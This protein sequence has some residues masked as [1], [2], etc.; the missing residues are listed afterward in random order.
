M[1]QAQSQAQLI[2]L[3]WGTSSLRAYLL[4]GPEKVV[5]SRQADWGIMHL[6]ENGFAGA[7]TSL[8]G[9]WLMQY[10][11]LPILAAG[12]VGSAQGWREAP[13]VETPANVVDLALHLVTTAGP[14]GRPVH[15]APGVIAGGL[16]PNVMRGE[17]TQILGALHLYPA[18]TASDQE[19]LI[20]LPGTHSKW[21]KVQA[22]RI[23][24]FTTFM[25]GEVYSALRQH[26]ILG[27]LMSYEEDQD[28]ER[29]SAFERG[30][31][32]AR[33]HP[34]SGVLSKLISVRTLGLTNQLAPTQLADYLSGLLIGYEIVE[35]I[36]AFPD[37]VSSKA[38]PLILIGDKLLCERYRIAISH[39]G[40]SADRDEIVDPTQAGLWHL[41]SAAGLIP[42]AK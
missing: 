7:L 34:Q 14:Q 19:Q 26:T 28:L 9:D 1:N 32:V 30:L 23:E 35:A 15:I 41:A 6:P 37:N 40:L 11:Q 25:T 22:G 13:Y 4:A 10:P 20:V 21:V 39:F 17:E 16:F 8:C 24:N 12:M 31:H 5:E 36:L 3:D 2:A 27:R 18:L 33:D 42:T 29:P 38:P